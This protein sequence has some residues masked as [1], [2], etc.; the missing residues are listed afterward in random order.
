MLELMRR[1]AAD[2]RGAVAVLVAVMLLPVLIGMAALVVDV[3]RMYVERREL[4]G[5]ADAAALAVAR[6]CA[7]GSCDPALAQRYADKNAKDAHS[8]VVVGVSQVECAAV[9]SSG[10]FVD[11]KTTTSS[12]TDTLLPQVFG[13]ALMGGSYA[14]ETL[15]ACARARWGVPVRASVIPITFNY[16][17][18]GLYTSGGT[19]FSTV[20][21]DFELH[22][23]DSC[24]HGHDFPGAW[25][26][27][28]EQ[29]ECRLSLTADG[30]T[31]VVDTGA[32]AGKAC[33]VIL[34]AAVDSK[35][36]VFIPIFDDYRGTGNNGSYHI[37]GFGAFILEGFKLPSI[38]SYGDSAGLQNG[39]RGRFTRALTAVGE[40][41]A[42]PD[43][44]L[45]VVR[46]TD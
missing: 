26:W 27:L 7:L 10:P 17:E 35:A 24:G 38:G 30:W 42:S 20:V 31:E 46:L 29:T 14:G 21:R 2:D 3:G 37:R 33:E 8:N 39:L 36:P 44:G 28:G 12:G 15:H 13:K 45:R 34:R 5:G 23:D 18:W 32:D 4:Q 22:E 19:S 1:R 16:C 43:L 25:G 9:A 11:A 6:S 41:G 40:L